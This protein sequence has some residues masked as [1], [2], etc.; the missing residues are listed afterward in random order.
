[1]QTLLYS[2]QTACAALGM[3][4]A[5]LAAL[6]LLVFLA[7]SFGKPEM[8]AALMLLAPVVLYAAAL[9]SGQILLLGPATLPATIQ[10]HLFQAR[11]GA[12]L[13]APCAVFVATL[14]ASLPVRKMSRRSLLP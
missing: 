6:S 3:A 13:V 7:R 14:A 12:G 11:L 1:M 2:G 9:C 10:D 5:A 4:L 8:F